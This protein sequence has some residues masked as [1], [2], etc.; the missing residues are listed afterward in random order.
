[1]VKRN[2]LILPFTVSERKALPINKPGLQ[3]DAATVSQVPAKDGVYELGDEQEETI[4]NR[5]TPSLLESLSEH[6]KGS[7]LGFL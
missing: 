6:L 5:A 2:V 7:S 1:M 4:L 3:F